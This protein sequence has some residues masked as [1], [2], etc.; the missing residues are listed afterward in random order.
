MEQDKISVSY[1]I[2][3]YNEET[4]VVVATIESIQ[5]AD[6]DEQKEIVLV[7]DGSEYDYS[8]L[9]ESHKIILCN[10]R[11]NK[12]YGASLA[13]GI[14][15]S[16]N[17]WIAIV[18]AD[19]TYPIEE[20]PNL[21]GE[22]GA[23]DMVIGA[24][25]WS[26]ISRIRKPAKWVLM[27]VASYL[28]QSKIPD[29]NSGMRVFRREIYE[30]FKRYYPT[31]FSFSST[32]T[33]VSLTHGYDVKFVSIDYHKRAGKSKISPI[34]DTIRFTTQLTRL[35]IYFNPMKVF[36]PLSL[37]F[38]ITSIIRGIR[39]VWFTEPQALGGMSQLLFVLAIQTFFFG[40]LAEIINKK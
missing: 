40:L 33:M 26:Q 3:C 12:G 22:A 29:L 5:K 25:K 7:N 36:V 24:R 31:K 32:L 6:G 16:Q 39:D 21:I 9:T 4:A 13:T 35:G 10:H 8:E 28:S 27:K 18:D 1:I 38:M 2:P 11:T 20:F 17:D 15:R 14:K 23:Y 37:F 30:N 34:K 19:A